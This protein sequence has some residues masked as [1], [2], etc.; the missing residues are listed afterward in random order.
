MFQYQSSSYL[1]NIDFLPT[2]L[3]E[4]LEK[5]ARFPFFSL[6][7]ELVLALWCY[8]V[9]NVA[10]RRSKPSKLRL[11]T[12]YSEKPVGRQLLE[13][14]RVNTQNGNFQWNALVPFPRLLPGR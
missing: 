2:S 13:M 1:G 10:R 3:P 4:P 12:I 7:F 8:T 11:F 5:E 14:V 6:Q 9:A